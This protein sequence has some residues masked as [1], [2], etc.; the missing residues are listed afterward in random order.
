MV[1][2]YHW[3]VIVILCSILETLVDD[4]QNCNVD[5]IPIYFNNFVMG[6]VFE[7]TNHHNY[8]AKSFI[9]YWI[10]LWPCFSDLNSIQLNPWMIVS[11]KA[12]RSL[13]FHNSITK[14]RKNK[15]NT[16]LKLSFHKLLRKS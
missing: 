2:S 13:G 11:N 1:N 16:K 4:G 10:K 15:K 12:P 14:H 9:L 8:E 3:L 6:V 5:Y 7:V